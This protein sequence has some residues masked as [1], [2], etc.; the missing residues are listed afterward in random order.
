MSKPTRLEEVEL[1]LREAAAEAGQRELT[2]A[3]AS[4][5]RRMAV[6]AQRLYGQVYSHNPSAHGTDMGFGDVR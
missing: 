5:I 1:A 4:A 3:E 2:D 6:I